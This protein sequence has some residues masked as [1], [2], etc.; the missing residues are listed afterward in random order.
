MCI[1]LYFPLGYWFIKHKSFIMTG[2]LSHTHDA[3]ILS[4]CPLKIPE[5]MNYT[6]FIWSKNFAQVNQFAW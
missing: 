2:Q 3:V 4:T 5:N 1:A 6:V